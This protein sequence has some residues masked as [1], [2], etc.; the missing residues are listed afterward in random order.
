[1]AALTC[2]ASVGLAIVSATALLGNPAR[3]GDLCPDHYYVS[4]GDSIESIAARCV[5]GRKHVAGKFGNRVV[6][7]RRIGRPMPTQIDSQHLETSQQ[8]RHLQFPHAVIG[9]QGMRQ[10]HQRL[11]R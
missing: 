7:G 10:H 5:H 2:W 6:A 4:P 3:A 11:P 8:R 9:P 1:M